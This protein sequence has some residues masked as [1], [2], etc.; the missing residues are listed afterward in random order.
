MNRAFP[1]LES[2]SSLVDLYD[3]VQKENELEKKSLEAKE[4]FDA[5][6]Q[7]YL[8]SISVIKAYQEWAQAL[9]DAK[10]LINGSN[11]ES[12]AHIVEDRQGLAIH[13][14]FKFNEWQYGNEHGKLRNRY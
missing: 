8:Q 4:D 1:I 11:G 12:I 5:V 3:L 6:S 14:N 10:K 2:G 7:S 9:D 13:I